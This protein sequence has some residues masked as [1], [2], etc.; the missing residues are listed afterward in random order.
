M[1]TQ[2]SFVSR[3]VNAKEVGERKM[4]HDFVVFVLSFSNFT[5]SKNISCKKILFG[6][7]KRSFFIHPVLFYFILFHSTSFILFYN[8][9]F[10]DFY[11]HSPL[12]KVWN[13]FF[14]SFHFYLRV[15]RS[16][17]TLT[18]FSLSNIVFFLSFMVS[19]LRCVF[20]H[21]FSLISLLASHFL[22][23]FS[24]YSFLVL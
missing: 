24:K 13:F 22:S 12:A 21:S 20:S 11:I 3:L 6:D 16:L 7:N 8:S 23:L 17:S 4:N 1:K 2:R 18:F 14:V 5:H 19:F 9:F 10:L 15:S